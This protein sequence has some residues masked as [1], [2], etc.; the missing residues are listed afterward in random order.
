MSLL[1]KIKD[2]FQL[3]KSRKCIEC[4]SKIEK[5]EKSKYVQIKRLEVAY[6][7]NDVYEPAKF[8]PIS[9]GNTIYVCEKCWNANAPKHYRFGVE[10]D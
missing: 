6:Q 2:N 4:S 8:S 9:A 1:Q 5:K 10:N 7:V 3:T